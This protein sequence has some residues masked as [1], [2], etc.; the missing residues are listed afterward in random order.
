MRLTRRLTIAILIAASMLAACNAAASPSASS[1]AQSSAV[2]SLVP[3]ASPP[4]NLVGKTWKLTGITETAPAFEG[5]VPDADRSKYTIEFQADGT[6]NAKAD[7]NKIGGTYAVRRGDGDTSLPLE[8]GGGS[9]SI[10]LGASTLAAC[11]PG[12]L[13]DRFVIALGNTS[14]FGIESNQL[15]ITLKDLGK[16]RFTS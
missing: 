13:A 7:C 5:V 15:T 10:L 2:A 3:G 14:S 4:A 6:F 1:S 9:I 8:P 12:S 16:L 11:P